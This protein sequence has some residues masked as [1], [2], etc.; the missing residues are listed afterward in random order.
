MTSYRDLL[1]EKQAK[2]WIKAALALNITKEGLH[3]FVED[4]LTCVHHDI[5]NT[6]RTSKSLQSGAICLHCFTENVLQCPT[7]GI[8]TSPKNCRFHKAANQMYVPCPN[9]ICGGVRNEII[10]HHRFTGPSWMNTNA[11]KW[12]TS[13]WEIG[14][15]FLPP[16]GY[17][18]VSSVKDSDFNSVISVMMNCKDFEKKLS[19]NIGAKT[20]LL[21][22]V[23]G[24]GRIVRHSHDQK[25]ED[26][27]LAN[28]FFKLRSL[29]EDQTDL[30]NRPEAQ[31]A[32]EQLNQ[33]QS[34]ELN[35]NAQNELEMLKEGLRLRLN[36]HY[37][38]T[39]DNMPISPILAEKDAK[40][41][42][43]Y[44][45]PTIIEKNHKKIGRVGQSGGREVAT[46]SDMFCHEG[47]F[48]RNVILV[49]E[50]GRG[51]TTFSAMCA[52]EWTH[53]YSQAGEKIERK[54]RFGDSDF[55]LE[56]LHFCSML[57]YE[58]QVRNA[59]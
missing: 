29:L 18:T 28:I 36:D 19:F 54:E 56:S 42:S 48:L 51:K 4:V 11:D 20:N 2:N 14:K 3:E 53:Q 39:L 5:Y 26:K 58:I 32:V 57:H 52:L 44:V 37:Q 38:T 25:I 34:D 1:R 16:D 7:R 50:P 17:K 9:G 35:I 43:C 41:S 49:G 23:R 47:H 21:S 27:P 24:F 59:I 22:E 40:L 12:C 6:I 10:Q 45:A 30:A 33:L 13:P 31:H 8:C 15:C 55:F 46:F